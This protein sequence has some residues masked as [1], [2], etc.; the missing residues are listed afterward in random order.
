MARPKTL[1]QVFDVLAGQSVNILEGIQGRFLKGVAIVQVSLNRGAS[2]L[3]TEVTIGSEQVLPSGPVTVEAAADE[4]PSI[5][6][7]TIIT[8]VGGNGDEVIVKAQNTTAGT[9]QSRAVVRITEFDDNELILFAQS[10][11]I[12]QVGV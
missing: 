1:T 5:R 11:G 8:T 12:I 6:D 2:G 3:N 4:L 7:D 9:I 10:K